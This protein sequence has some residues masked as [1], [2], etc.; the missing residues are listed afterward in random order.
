MKLKKGLTVSL[1]VL[2]LSA[3]LLGCAKETAEEGMAVI[4][5]ENSGEMAAEEV[6]DDG[7][8]EE[9]EDL[10]K[11]D[12]EE[13]SAGGTKE[14]ATESEPI[15]EEGEEAPEPTSEATPEPTP[16]VTPEPTP[17]PVEVTAFD[18]PQVRYATSSLNIRK[19]PGTEYEVIG[20][21]ALA[22][23][24]QATGQAE[25][26]WYQL[27]VGEEPGYVS[28]DYVSEEPV[29]IP[30]PEPT[31]EPTPQP[32][33]P[34]P[35]PAAPQ[36]PAPQTPAPPQI[37]TAPAGVIMVGDS[38]CVQMKDAVGGGGCM[39]FCENSK[40]YKWL[41]EKAL[42][43]MDKHV[44]AGTKVVINLGV[45]DP[46]NCKNYADLINGKAAE[47][48]QRGATTYYVTVNPV[49]DNPY[50]TRE[51][52]AAFNTNMP[53]WLSGVVWVD[54]YSSL[55]EGGCKIVD[56]LHYDTQTSINIFNMIMGKIS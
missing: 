37:V 26:G 39:W 45:N 3:G 33:A 12:A 19:G 41:V 42:P 10:A 24:M 16:E 53:G 27:M 7:T 18:A 54:T 20:R 40:G 43:A 30:T 13:G 34:A 1:C 6:S 56:G 29:V 52:V 21:L 51:E 2:L 48:A 47:W 5:T 14:A 15:A 38:R 55:M 35:Q 31:P 32:Q 44:G 25:N 17:E 4:E 50:T 46:E 36:P 28:G 8:K 11:A 22:E 49:W 9:T 23:E